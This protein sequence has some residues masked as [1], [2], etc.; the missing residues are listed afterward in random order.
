[1]KPTILCVD[2]EI[3]N[4]EALERLFR[5]KYKVLKAISGAEALLILDQHPEPISVILTDQR[6]PGMT[7]VQ[8]L[9]HS[10]VTHPAAVRILLTG[11]TDIES[12]IEA[13]NSGQIYR[14]LNKPWDP[15]DLLATVDRAVEKFELAAQLEIR[16]AELSEALAE[17]QRL[18]D[19]KN[20]FMILIN[21]EL[22]TPLTSLINFTSLLKETRLSEEQETCV[23][24]IEKSN[25]RLQSLIEDALF[26]VQG[27][28]G[29]LKVNTTVFA[30]S[31]LNLQLST[32]IQTLAQQKKLKTIL[33][34][35]ERPVRADRQLLQQVVNRLV[36]NAIKF[37]E[38]SSQ[39]LVRVELAPD[40]Q[41]LRFAV[42]NRGPS[43][44]AELID[45]IIQPFYLDENVMHHA[46]GMGLG[47]TI[48]QSILKAHGQQLLIENRDEGVEVSFLLPQG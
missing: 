5:S 22:K 42:Y 30:V 15:V 3:D 44:P 4:V 17:L 26:V 16:N 19:A 29:L 35:G 37:A 18:D 39:I 24:R 36:H 45:K 23:R 41:H 34:W 9:E 11:Y 25:N 28:T 21:H 48:C 10:I 33:R 40:R 13:V 12:I 31:V 38:D 47:L 27:E 2:D 7:G 46:V 1:M 43:I 32:E 14:Y 6:M 20:R 8:F